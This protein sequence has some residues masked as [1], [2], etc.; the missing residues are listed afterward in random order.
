LQ[1]EEEM[2]VL[3]VDDEPKILEV[4]EAYLKADYYEVIRAKNGVD[5]LVQFEVEQPDFI[6]LDWMMPGMDGIE[7]I[8][9]IRETS[10]VPIIMLTAKAD[11]DDIIS[12]LDVGADDYMTKPFNPRELLARIKSVQRRSL[13]DEHADEQSEIVVEHIKMIL[14]SRR[15]I[16]SGVEVPLTSTEFDLLKL[17][18]EHPQ[19]VFSREHL[20]ESVMGLDFVGSDRAIDSHIKNLRQKV[21]K[22]S[23]NPKLIVTVHGQGYRSGVER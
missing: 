18:L 23:K 5:A 2:K 11:E 9:K 8:K 15:V 7:V 17:F 14:E 16:V 12:A 10:E 22:D 19:V 13:K 21:E 1:Q 4:V 6:I 20:I 3:I